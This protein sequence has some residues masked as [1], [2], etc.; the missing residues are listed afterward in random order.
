MSIDIEFESLSELR[1]K[2]N[3]HSSLYLD[4]AVLRRFWRLGGW[5]LSGSRDARRVTLRCS[6]HSVPRPLFRRYLTKRIFCRVLPDIRSLRAPAR[7]DP[8][9]RL[10]GQRRPITSRA[11]GAPRTHPAD[12]VHGVRESRYSRGVF[13]LGCAGLRCPSYFMARVN[14]GTTTAN[15]AVELAN[16]A[17]RCPWQKL[18]EGIEGC[19][20]ML[21]R[22]GGLTNGQ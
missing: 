18:G 9:A 20:G 21:L 8:E 3:A 15:F 17:N 2:L 4:F 1:E 22:K 19:V 13:S 7:R 10:S 16:K 12:E 14:K 11:R 6:L 5:E